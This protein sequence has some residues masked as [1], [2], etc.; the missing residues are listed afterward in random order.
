[1]NT[2]KMLTLASLTLSLTLAACGGG[3]GSAADPV[4]STQTFQV[5]QAWTNY[6][7][8]AQT[9][10]F[11][12]S[13][14]Y[15]GAS[16]GGSGTSTRGAL[17]SATF[18]GTP[19]LQKTSVVTGT[20]IVNGTNVPYNGT[21]TSYVTS[22]YLPLGYSGSEYGVVTGTVSVPQTGRVNDAGTLYTI[23]RYASS[24]KTTPKGS[25]VVSYALQPDTADTALLKVV[26]TERTTTGALESTSTQTFR[27]TPAGAL[28][29]VSEETTTSSYALTLRY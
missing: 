21:Q 2:K 27:M 12:V 15:S 20:L 24:T 8:T 10:S 13:G 11:S 16:V 22:N 9:R 18:E 26:T 14:T 6:V 1:M 25:T 23:S 17:S 4:T 7:T 19:A 5:W 29:P 28:T 3:G